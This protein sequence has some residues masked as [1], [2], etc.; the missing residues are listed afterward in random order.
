MDYEEEKYDLL[1]TFFDTQA[2]P[3]RGVPFLAA[4]V[5]FRLAEGPL[6]EARATHIEIAS[7]LGVSRR[8]V[9][10]ALRRVEQTGW[11]KVVKRG[12]RYAPGVY[13]LVSP[14]SHLKDRN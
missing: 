2:I 14:A 6:H 7:R 12:T 9:V 4:V 5:L 1:C 8:T 3:L 13:R 10:S 11:L